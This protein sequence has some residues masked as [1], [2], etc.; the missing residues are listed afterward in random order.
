[1]K[2][3]LGCLLAACLLVPLITGIAYAGQDRAGTSVLTL[4]VYISGSDLE[5]GSSSGSGNASASSTASVTGEV[6]VLS[7]FRGTF[8]PGQKYAVYSAPSTK[9]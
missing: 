7:F 4:M 9:A 6:P 3:F 2:R 5:T 1:M 8:E